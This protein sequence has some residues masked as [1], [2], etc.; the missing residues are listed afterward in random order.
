MLVWSKVEIGVK[1]AVRDPV[2]QRCGHIC[3]LSHNSVSVDWF[4]HVH[5]FYERVHVV[6]MVS[7]VVNI[8]LEISFEGET[9]R[10]WHFDQHQKL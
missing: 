2:A 9:L 3:F 6:Y 1:S 8:E 5:F 10:A 7:P 4:Q